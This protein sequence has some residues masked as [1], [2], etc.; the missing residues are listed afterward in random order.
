MFYEVRRFVIDPAAAGAEPAEEDTE[1]RFHVLN[2]SS[3]D[4][5]VIETPG[6]RSHEL[7]FAETLSAGSGWRLPAAAV[8]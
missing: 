1:G 7:V 2:V 8:G 5:V 3:G 4:G 6:G